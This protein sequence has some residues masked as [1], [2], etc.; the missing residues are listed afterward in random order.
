MLDHWPE[1][2]K[3][4]RETCPES[5]NE[6]NKRKCGVDNFLKQLLYTVQ[7]HNLLDLPESAL[8]QVRNVVQRGELGLDMRSARNILKKYPNLPIHD[9]LRACFVRVPNQEEESVY[10]DLREHIPNFKFTRE[11]M[12]IALD[13]LRELRASW[14][15][16]QVQSVRLLGDI[17]N[18]QAAKYCIYNG[19]FAEFRWALLLV[20]GFD[21]KEEVN[22]RYQARTLLDARTKAQTLCAQWKLPVASGVLAYMHFYDRFGHMSDCIANTSVDLLVAFVKDIPRAKITKAMLIRVAQAHNREDIVRALQIQHTHKS[23]MCGWKA[24]VHESLMQLE[25]NNPRTAFMDRHLRSTSKHFCSFVLFLERQT[26]PTTLESFLRDAD[27][28]ALEK[29]LQI[30]VREHK[31][32]N[33]RVKSRV[34]CHPA[35]HAAVTALRFVKTVLFKHLGCAANISRITIQTLLQGIPNER[36][37]CN[38]RRTFHDREVEDMFRV[39]RNPVETLLL[40]LLREIGLRNAALGH[41]RCD[42]IVDVVSGAPKTRCAVV[43]KGNKVRHFLCSENLQTAAQNAF[44]WLQKKHHAT[45]WSKFYMFNLRKPEV[46][47]SVDVLNRTLSR[48]ASDAGITGVKVHAHAFRHTLVTKLVDVGNSMDVVSKYIGHSSVQTTS[49]FYWLPD[50]EQLEKSLINPFRADFHAKKVQSLESGIFCEL[51]NKKIVA[52]RKILNTALECCPE[53]KTALRTAL[54][55]YEN[56]LQAIDEP[57]NL[58]MQ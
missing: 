14:R 54:P 21:P 47:M 27:V 56:I 20:C 35:K 2:L 6:A 41:L 4:L 10:Q 12:L 19:P 3:R 15:C 36:I 34:G 57:V 24:E 13:R 29:L 44:V 32:C 48:I 25:R 58:A 53:A 7:P 33:E 23:K 17:N 55:E 22:V 52:L 45:D 38:K 16:E 43:E 50:A 49:Y 1:T 42:Q 11:N 18:M 30:Y 40:T 8:N 28:N 5:R 37:V 31:V 26:H 51:A 39:A 46:P 9:S